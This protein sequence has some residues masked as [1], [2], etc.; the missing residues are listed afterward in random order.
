MATAICGAFKGIDYIKK[1]Y[2]EILEKANDVDF[3]RYISILMEG[4]SCI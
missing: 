3:H 1:G 4:R 2:I